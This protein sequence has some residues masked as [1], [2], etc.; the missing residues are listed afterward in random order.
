MSDSS[1]GSSASRRLAF[2]DVLAR[3]YDDLTPS[4]SANIMV[5]SSED[6]HCHQSIQSAPAIMSP[7]NEE[8]YCAMKGSAQEGVTSLPE[9]RVERSQHR[10][11]RKSRWLYP[12]VLSAA[13][14]LGLAMGVGSVNAILA[15]GDDP[16]PA[17]NASATVAI[18]NENAS[19]LPTPEPTPPQVLVTNATIDADNLPSSTH[20]QISSEAPTTEAHTPTTTAIFRP[21]KRDASSYS[22]SLVAR[23]PPQQAVF[24]AV[25]SGVQLHSPTSAS[26]LTPTF[27]PSSATTVPQV[28][29]ASDITTSATT[30]SKVPTPVVSDTFV[31]ATS[32]SQGSVTPEASR[33]PSTLES[34]PL[35]AESSSFGPASSIG[36]SAPYAVPTTTSSTEA[37]TQTSSSEQSSSGSPATTESPASTQASASS[38]ATASAP[39]TNSK[40]AEGNPAPLLAQLK[41]R[42]NFASADCAAVVHRTSPGTKF[43]SSILNEKKDRYMRSPCTRSRNSQD[44]HGQ[45]VILELC[46]DIMID[47]VVLGNYEFFSSQFKRFRLR[48]AAKLHAR[49]EEWYDFGTFRARNSRG[50]QVFVVNS[51]YDEGESVTASTTG[52]VIPGYDGEEGTGSGSGEGDGSADTPPPPLRPPSSSASRKVARFFRY[53]R[54]DFL[55]HYGS[56]FYC[57]VSVVRVFGMTALDEFYSDQEAHAAGEGGAGGVSAPVSMNDPI[58]ATVVELADQLDFAYQYAANGWGNPPGHTSTELNEDRLIGDGSVMSDKA[59][60]AEGGVD[61]HAGQ[62][63]SPFDDM[64]NMINAAAAAVASPS[65]SSVLST[66]GASILQS[67]RPHHNAAMHWKKEQ[68][69]A[70]RSS[71][72]ATVAA[73]TNEEDA[74]T[75]RID[76]NAGQPHIHVKIPGAGSALGADPVVVLMPAQTTCAP[77]EE[78]SREQGQSELNDAPQVPDSITSS[79][80]VP[81]TVTNHNMPVSTA[82]ALPETVPQPRSSVQ[83][84]LPP[85]TSSK[86]T[87]S[88]PLTSESIASAAEIPSSSTTPEGAT[89]LQSVS[90]SSSAGQNANSSEPPGSAPGSGSPTIQASEQV[91][92]TMLAGT[93]RS[94]PPSLQGG[95]VPPGQDAA[96][97]KLVNVTASG[98]PSSASNG[99]PSHIP[100][101]RPASSASYSSSVPVA[102]P[103]S[104]HAEPPHRPP[105]PPPPSSGGAG[106]ESIYRAI[107]KRLSA[108]E[109]NSTLNLAFI[110]HSQRLLRDGFTTMA[111]RHQARIDEMVR[112]LNASNWRQF[113]LL[114]RRTQVDLQRALFESEMR[115]Q[116]ADS[117]RSAM[118]SQIHLLTEE[119]LMQKRISLAQLVLIF[120]LFVF[121]TL[122]RG[123]RAPLIQAGLGSRLGV[124]SRPSTPNPSSVGGPNSAHPTTAENAA[125]SSTGFGLLPPGNFLRQRLNRSRR[126][127]APTT[128]VAPTVRPASAHGD[129]THVA[130]QP[131]D[132]SRLSIV[133]PSQ[134]Q[135]TS[136]Y[137][138]NSGAS[139][140]NGSILELNEVPPQTHRGIIGEH[141]RERMRS[142]GTGSVVSFL[143]DHF[144]D[145]N[146]EDFEGLDGDDPDGISGS[147]A[148]DSKGVS[149]ALRRR[150]TSTTTSV[151]SASVRSG[152]SDSKSVTFVAGNNGPVT[153]SS[154][155]LP[156]APPPFTVKKEED[157]EVARNAALLRSNS[158]SGGFTSVMSHKNRKKKRGASLLGKLGNGTTQNAGN[159]PGTI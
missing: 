90:P 92:A 76:V 82:S 72:A 24:E 106:T 3:A 130:H 18:T 20:N 110:E 42:W 102:P 105:P 37:S 29:D 19:I 27:S 5:S 121:V 123:I 98:A 57:P 67:N 119:V 89:H 9:G 149:E 34:E 107:N 13:A 104:A 95:V 61:G 134:S 116:Q 14:I 69:A 28:T 70:S 47:T 26:T 85:A 133:V 75:Y 147:R 128:S 58:V 11:K 22:A 77:E 10:R 64:E 93:E 156:T 74:E 103:A 41:H 138:L 135:P 17:A 129:P 56:E 60:L 122:T 100:S 97:A 6:E 81:H 117:E 158:T 150:S 62:I 94:V 91:N 96:T 65:S 78:A 108:L 131:M 40:P 136:V 68:E 36:T 154:K 83:V 101:S 132:R 8:S 79:A 159:S 2:A 155:L 33:P 38:S 86:I 31:P 51:R 71:A 109:Y 59:S 125:A 52:D 12:G 7:P 4:S 23:D 35:S 148:R 30:E 112:V 140:P 1:S 44:D 15:P 99:K 45:F 157:D 127:S 25:S 139:S 53:V 114:R 49:E 43:A 63:T 142:N 32:A 46:D 80:G 137:R 16:E 21:L 50:E 143:E 141:W 126:V 48:A 151:T 146:E 152:G 84:D 111:E 87:S 124:S 144:S 88:P 145:L 66:H 118:I 120:G 39:I 113:D 54:I 153:T 55:E 73:M 115:R